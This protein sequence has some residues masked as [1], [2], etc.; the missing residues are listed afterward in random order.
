MSMYTTDF[1]CMLFLFFITIVYFSSKRKKTYQHKLFKFMLLGSYLV[2]I[3]E[4]VGTFCSNNMNQQGVQQMG[5]RNLEEMSESAL[6]A[7]RVNIAL[8]SNQVYILSLFFFFYAIY[9]YVR[10]MMTGKERNKW[11][12]GEIGMLCPFAALV[13]F[14]AVFSIIQNTPQENIDDWEVGSPI[15]P[16]CA[17][18]YLL[19]SVVY[20]T[21]YWRNVGKTQRMA[22][23]MAML[24]ECAVTVIQTVFSGIGNNNIAAIGVVLM[25]FAFYMTVESPDA[26]LIENL[27]Y[28][29]ERADEANEAKSSFLANMSHEIRTPMNAIVGM[30]EILLRTD[31]TPQ[32]KSYMYNIKH[33]GNSLLLI[34][35]DLLDFSKI[36]AGK[37]ELVNE[38]Y[39]PMS[40]FN[41]VS[42]IILNRIG[43]KPVELLYDVDKNIPSKLYGDSGR[44]KQIIINLMNNAVKFTDEGYVKLS[45]KIV[46]TVGRTITIRFDIQDTGQGIKQEDIDKLF[47]A[48]KQVDMA[49]N[50]KKEGTGLGLSISKRL[51]NLMGGDV[52]VESEYGKGS[53]FYFT[54]KQK[55]SGADLAVILKDSVTKKESAVVGAC[56]CKHEAEILK[57]LSENYELTYREISED[58]FNVDGVTH[59][60]LDDDFYTGHKDD[61]DALSAKGMDIAVLY[62]PMKNAY[63]DEKVT[64]L[65]RPFYSFTFCKFMNHEAE[66]MAY[67]EGETD[68]NIRFSA[69]DAEVLLV[70]DTDMNLKVAVGLLAPLN[71]KVDVAHSGKEAIGKAKKKKYNLVFMD[72]MM[73][74]MDGIETI[75]NM[76]LIEEQ[77][78]YY[79]TAKIIA[80]TANAAGEAKEAFKA[81]GVDEFV[82]KP[83]EIKQLVAAIKRNLPQEKIK[84]PLS[85]EE[86]G[87][88]AAIKMIPAIKGIDAAEGIK[89]SG[90]EELFEN[91]LGDFYKLIDMKSAKI[92]KCLE[93]GMVKDFT[94]EVHALKNTARMIGALELSEMFKEMEDLG[95]EEKVEEIHEK[96]PAL[97]NKYRGYKAV[98]LPYANKNE[99]EKEEV[100]KETVLEALGDMKDAME[101]FDLDRADEDMKKLETYKMDEATR[102]LMENLRAYI[103]D[104]AM[105]DVMKTCDDLIQL[106]N[107]A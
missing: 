81:V 79:K 35:N 56:L 105:E 60:I 24:G 70:D 48:F 100:S 52:F 107:L 88:Q 50:R 10:Y 12:K 26:L 63:A 32:Q 92:E 95:H 17:A 43:D 90:T 15:T 98:L 18:F 23:I 101:N 38:D 91:L 76:R 16:I 29:K 40:L 106:I 102:P 80:L 3:S 45:A 5:L 19:V 87:P 97:L 61:V 51:A 47:D 82:T 4:A 58:E 33:S 104:V 31:L 9:L 83:I 77:D 46:E 14:A 42:M 85:P 7:T 20:I 30:T 54:I 103:A 22:V 57:K 41:D 8:I 89:N 75:K 94:I 36:E 68:E 66:N 84:K 74:G 11:T 62:N 64:F 78:G 49:R 44:I 21:K 25:D 67:A 34:I 72:H 71:M 96:L 13:L 93:D 27:K 1:T 2:V 39:D 55:V 37:M 69:P 6:Q 73:P 99:E 28:Q 65:P 59:L 53:D 86:L